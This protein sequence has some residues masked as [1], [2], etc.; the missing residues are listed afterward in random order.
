MTKCPICIKNKPLESHL[1]ELSELCRY[2][3]NSVE[4]TQHGSVRIVKTSVIGDWLKLASHLKK[5]DMEWWR[6]RDEMSDVYCPSDVDDD[7]LDKEHFTEFSTALTRF[8]YVTNAMDEAYRFI[9][10]EYHSLDTVVNMP[11]DKRLREP[12]MR[13]IVVIDLI[14]KE[15]LPENFFHIMKNLEITF[16]KYIKHF[17]LKVNGIND[18]KETDNSAGLHF[19]RNLRNHIAHGVFP[20][21]DNPEYKGGEDKKR[22]LLNLLF[23]AC[24]A[25]AIYIQTILFSFNEGFQS[26]DYFD[27]KDVWDEE[28]DYFESNCKIELAKSLHLNGTFSFAEPVEPYC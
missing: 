28:G 4:F 16:G 21:I 22:N 9:D 10:K 7:A 20:V 1:F 19:I 26:Q 2:L 5:V 12:S 23:H 8:M 14:H 11:K 15:S 18:I 27:M 17:S 6:Y 24:R 25:S 13:A 3:G